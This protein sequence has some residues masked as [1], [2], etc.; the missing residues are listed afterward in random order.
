MN[1]KNH[2]S[3]YEGFLIGRHSLDHA[4]TT[5]I[6][7][8]VTTVDAG[9]AKLIITGERPVFFV[10]DEDYSKLSE[11]LSK[12]AITYECRSVE[13]VTFSH[14][15][16]RAV[17][18]PTLEAGFKAQDRLKHEGMTLFEA[19][20]RLHERYLME[21]FVTGG[22]A[23]T[24]RAVRQRGY[25]EF[26]DV[27]VR[28]A[29]VNPLFSVLSLD[30]ECSAGG[31]LYSIG[32]AGDAVEQVLMIGPEMSS[33]NSDHNS[34]AIHWVENERSLLKTLEE[35]IEWLDPDILLGW[36]V[37]NFDCRL[38]FERAR[39]HGFRLCLGRGRQA[40][41]WRERRGE[42]GVGFVTVPGRVVIDGIDAL[43]SATYQFADFTLETVS[44]N[45]L[46]RGKATE[47]VDNRVAAITHDFHHDKHKLAK[48]N[49]EDCRLVLDIFHQ[50]R[51]LD[52]LRLRSQLTGL[53]LDRQGGSVAAFTHLYLPRLHRAGYVAPNL[54]EAGGQ[55]SPGGY[56]MD[57][58][59]GLYDNVLVL[60]FKS[61]Y[62]SIIRTFK[63]DPLGL[64]EGLKQ[65]EQAI[66]GY[67]GAL[68]SREHHFLPA[69][70]TSLW[71]QR[72]EAKQQHDSARSQAIKILMNSFYG[73]LGSGGCRFYDTRLASSIT[74][75]GHAIM[76]QTARWI[77][78]GGYQVIYGDTD[79][80]FVRL[81]DNLSPLEADR[82]GKALVMDINQRWRETLQQE[83]RLESYLE[84]EFETHYVRFLMPT[85][86]GSETG[87]KKR[88]AGLKWA[89]EGEQLVFKGLESVRSDWTPLARQFQVQLFERVFAGQSPADLVRETVMQTLAGERDNELVYRK[90]LRRPLS[91]YVRSSP[92]HVRAARQA[93]AHNLS[94]GK[95]LR[96]QNRGWINYI[97]T[98]NGPE[99][100]EYRVSPIDYQHY[101]DK[102][103]KPV[104]E[105]VLPFIGEDFVQLYDEQLRLF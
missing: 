61:L 37:V 27:K 63:I 45:L 67:R 55:A 40:A 48:Y 14:E 25:T 97:I 8:W 85:I 38:L 35:K 68:F 82:V 22:V 7:L 32:L 36:N 46:G 93:D 83:F 10:R 11:S 102:Q 31:E 24:G 17:Y 9:V 44:Q 104:A 62:P 54:P 41:S 100:V 18:T 92:P 69:I 59:P 1:R 64:V 23:F 91:Q 42:S 89:P 75:R 5:E 73:V 50:T 29:D 57:S 56:V 88:Y 79:S 58:K 94:A 30:I 96:Y 3:I 47:D 51:L 95:S 4:G 26:H 6:H 86:R 52:F 99:A 90:R 70:I 15:S 103:L 71:L 16:V 60:D 19:D 87:S 101:I 2:S 20:I 39:F 77:E 98:V 84:L 66:P 81:A 33:K 53:E 49:L 13:L 65:P 76:Q 28:P 43:K 105:A 34:D 12:A 74:L 80:L 21:R 72:D 78:A